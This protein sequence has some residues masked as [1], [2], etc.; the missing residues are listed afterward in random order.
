MIPSRDGDDDRQASEHGSAGS[1]S[2]CVLPGADGGVLGGHFV[3]AGHRLA[4]QGC[5][6]TTKMRLP[7]AAV[8]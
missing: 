4:L 6:A 8:I 5:R 2:E 3:G 7:E 1:A